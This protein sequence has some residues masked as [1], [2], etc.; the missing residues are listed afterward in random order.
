MK[1]LD[2]YASLCKHCLFLCMQNVNKS[3]CFFA[4]KCFFYYFF[5]YEMKIQNWLDITYIHVEKHTSLKA[6][7]YASSHHLFSSRIWLSSSGVK[8]LMILNVS[9]ICSGVF[10][11]IILA[12]FAHV[13]SNKDLISI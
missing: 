12:T 7:Y 8:S 13:K 1:K 2:E 5:Q 11:L 3:C 10:P 6:S 4:C 9:R